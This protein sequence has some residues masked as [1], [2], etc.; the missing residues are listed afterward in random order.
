M[1]EQD[2]SKINIRMGAGSDEV[3]Y[4]QNAQ[5]DLDGGDGYDTLTIIGMLVIGC[6]CSSVQYDART[7][8]DR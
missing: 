1:E 2:T 4:V 6:L 3:V 7:I 8:I 5:V